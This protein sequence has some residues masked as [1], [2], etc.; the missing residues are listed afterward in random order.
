MKTFNKSIFVFRRDLRLDDNIGLLQAL[1][2]SNVVICIFILTPEQLEQNKFKSSNAIQ[3]MVEC[4]LDLESQLKAKQSKLFYFYGKPDEILDSL[5][6]ELDID[7]VF[8]NEDYTPYSKLRDEK[9]HKV[10]TTYDTEF[11]QCCDLLLQEKNAVLSPSTHDVYVKFTP[12]YLKAKKLTVKKPQKNLFKNYTKLKTIKKEYKKELDKFYT[13]NE[14]I[15]VEGG[16]SNALKIMAKIKSFKNYNTDRDNLEKNTTM[17][18]AYIKFG[19]LSIREIYHKIKDNLPSKNDL[20][21]QLYWRDFYYRILDRYPNTLNI[22]PL[23]K[24]LKPQYDRIKW[25]TYKTS[26]AAQKKDW[27]RW[28]DGLTGFPLVDAGMRELNK[29]GYMKNRV[30]MVVASFL[31][32]NMFWHYL[33]GEKYFAQKL[34]DYDPANNI[35]GWGWVSGSHAD[36]QPYFRVFNPFLQSLNH[37]KNCIYIKKWII[38]LKNV[39]PKHIHRWDLHNGLYKNIKYPKPML[40][41]A[42]SA[43]LCIQKYKKALN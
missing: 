14:F 34:V 6:Y 27:Y 15:A 1:N 25:I 36:S 42:S 19:C 21:K 13:F 39:E 24:S 31:I 22:T 30:R 41:Y 33:E 32:K 26:T 17:L 3:F 43:Q 7:A 18:S 38:E 35:G 23:K 12:F 9:I 40:D 37:D 5:I 20:I 11:I 10:C 28:T 8:V 2:K 4:L 29:T 16:R